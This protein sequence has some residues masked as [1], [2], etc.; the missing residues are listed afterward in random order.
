MRRSLAI[1]LVALFVGSVSPSAHAALTHRWTFEEPSG[2]P[3]PQ[4][5]DSAGGVHGSF[6][7]M[8]DANRSTDVPPPPSYGSTRSLSFGGQASTNAVVLNSQIPL[9]NAATWT[10]AT[11]YKGTEAGSNNGVFGA[12]LLGRDNN[13]IFANFVIYNGK[14][15]YLHWNGSWQQ[16]SSTTS[17]NDNLWHHLA[18]VHYSD[19]TAD[20]YVDGV[21]ETT[22][23]ATDALTAFPFRIDN[24]MLGYSGHYTQGLLDDVRI[25]NTALTTAEI[26]AQ[27][28]PEPTALALLTLGG[29]ILGVRGRPTDHR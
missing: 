7:N 14:A 13:D 22:G 2:T 25:Y 29:V 19:Q 11:W 4:V 27:V 3:A 10:V 17:V 8:T 18:V 1:G 9:A 21:K 12:T 15:A 5:L 20:I 28:I 6:S 16:L 26:N 23:D 24:M